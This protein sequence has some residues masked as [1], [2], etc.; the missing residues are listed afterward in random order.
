MKTFNYKTNLF[1]IHISQILINIHL[2]T[3]I[4]ILLHIIILIKTT[5]IYTLINIPNLVNITTQIYHTIKKSFI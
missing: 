2:I 5:L 1:S 3:T 4:Q